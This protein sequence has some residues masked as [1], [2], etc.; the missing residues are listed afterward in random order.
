MSY[1]QDNAL[2]LLQQYEYLTQI[3]TQ[4][5]SCLECIE[6]DNEL[7][8]RLNKL[9]IRLGELDDLILPM[10]KLFSET[11]RISSI[12]S[13]KKTVPHEIETIIREAKEIIKEAEALK[14]LNHRTP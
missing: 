9:A 7:A 12:F 10:H 5:N 13:T 1:D 2:R 8:V 4:I 14:I 6:N 11:G 3:R